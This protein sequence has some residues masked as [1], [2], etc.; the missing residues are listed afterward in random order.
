MSLNLSN[1]WRGEQELF[2]RELA[3]DFVGDYDSEQRSDGQKGRLLVEMSWLEGMGGWKTGHHFNHSKC[4]PC[5]HLIQKSAHV[6]L[7]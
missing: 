4:L 5:R 2:D 6:Q 1:T 7:S 3:E